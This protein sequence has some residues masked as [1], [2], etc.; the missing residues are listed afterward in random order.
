VIGL[1]ALAAGCGGGAGDGKPRNAI[2]ISIDTLRPDHLGSYGHTRDTSPTLD[3]IAAE[4][5]RF[6]DVTAPSPWTLPSHATMLTGLYPSRHGVKTHETRLSEEVV[7]LAE[8]FRDAGYATFAVVNTHNVGAPQFQLSQGFADEH[9]SYIIETEEDL[10][11]MKLRTHNSGEQIVATAKDFLR[12]RADDEPFFLFLH[13]YDVH[14]DFT[15]KDEYREK[16][17]GPYAGR[18]TGSTIQLVNVRNAEERLSDAD[19]RWLR[20]MYD[21]E[22][23]QLDDLLG[24]FLGWLDDEGELD[25]TLLVV[26]SDH[27]EE[28]QEHGSVLHGRTHYQEVARVPL[29]VRGPGVPSATVVSTPV[30]GIDVTPTILGVMGIPSRQARDGI[31]LSPAWSGGALPERTF[32]AEADHN[33]QVEGVLVSDIKKMVR[34]GSTKLL[35][36]THTG[37]VELYDIGRDAAELQDLAPGAPERVAELRALLERFL[38]VEVEAEA[39]PPPSEEERARLE[40]L[41]Y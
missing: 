7:T 27:G 4:G 19:V 15:P 31:D 20:E 1:A 26:T 25:E 37:A 16:Y 30:H 10:V 12:S 5:V 14:T 40:A 35:L 2:L 3:R 39:V 29:L 13:F 23:R 32:F 21:A 34:Q 18:L 36:D 11:S 41:G 22:I 9:F 17:V 8:E 6:E 33:N 28:F 38:A 24:R